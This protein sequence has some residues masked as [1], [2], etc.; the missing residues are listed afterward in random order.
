MRDKFRLGLFD[1]PYVSVEDAPKITGQNAFRLKGDEALRKSTV[2]LKNDNLL[3]SKKGTKVYAEGML[4]PDDINAY[5]VLVDSPEDADVIVT[6]IRTPF[7]PRSEYMLEQFFHQGRLY[8]NQEELDEILSLIRRKP[9]I[10]VTNLERPAILTE[11]DAEAGAMMADF[12]TTDKILAELLFGEATPTAKMPFEL[13][14]SW[15]AVE[16]QYEDVPYD[17]KDPLYPFGHGLT[18]D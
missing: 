7:D 15:E 18:Y 11:I 17:S 1:D 3:P 14:S 8:F 2:L 13:P 10:V 5:G 9:A 16:N 6:R 12:G 4:T